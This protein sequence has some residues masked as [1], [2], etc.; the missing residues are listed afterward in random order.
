MKTETL[1]YEGNVYMFNN[2]DVEW[3]RTTHLTVQQFS[4]EMLKQGR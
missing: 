3:Y 4:I 2:H 1:R